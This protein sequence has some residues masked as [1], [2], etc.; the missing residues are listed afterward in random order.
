MR[1]EI[2]DKNFIQPTAFRV[3][4]PLKGL[5]IGHPFPRLALQSFCGSKS[6]KKMAGK[7]TSSRVESRFKG[8]VS[9]VITPFRGLEPGKRVEVDNLFQL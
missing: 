2:K 1:K 3:K 7:T 4:K 9:V 6:G 8:W 5:A